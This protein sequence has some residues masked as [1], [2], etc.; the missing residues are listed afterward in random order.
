LLAE[1][2][3][4]LDEELLEMLLSFSEFTIFKQMML[5]FKSSKAN[6]DDILSIDKPMKTED[7]SNNKNIQIVLHNFNT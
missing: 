1:K 3:D 2:R 6:F 7:E 5:D 4:E